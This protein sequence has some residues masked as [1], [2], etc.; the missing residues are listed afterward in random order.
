MEKTVLNGL[1]AKLSEKPP[2]E[3]TPEQR[4]AELGWIL[5]CVDSDRGEWPRRTDR[6]LETC[7]VTMVGALLASPFFVRVYDL[8]EPEVM[9]LSKDPHEPN[10][11]PLGELPPDGI[12]RSSEYPDGVPD[13]ITPSDP[14][15]DEDV[16]KSEEAAAESEE[17]AAEEEKA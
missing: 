16:A 12:L 13:V 2:R 4:K 6:P 15:Q 7:Y 9:P 14:I 17:A 3:L 1:M 11:P 5:S 10:F 8:L